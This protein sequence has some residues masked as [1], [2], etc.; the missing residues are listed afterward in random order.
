MR[1][2]VILSSLLHFALFIL[3]FFGLPNFMSR[4][5]DENQV[6]TVEILPVSE[7]TNVKPKSVK[8]QLKPMV[9]KEVTSATPQKQSLPDPVQKPEIAKIAEPTPKLKE[10][11]KEVKKAEVAP[12]VKP[13]EEKKPEPDKTV[14]VKKEVEPELDFASVLKSVEQFKEVKSDEKAKEED[15]FDDVEDFLSNV[16]EQQ[17]KPGIPLSLSEKDAIRQQ[18]SRNWTG[19][20]GGKSAGEIVVTLVI[21]LA[22][23]GEVTKV[24]NVDSNRYKN[25][26]Y[27]KAMADSAIRAVYKSSPLK[28]LPPEK[29]AVKDGW[30]E[31]KLNFDPKEMFY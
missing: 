21:H 12:L 30:R 25:D 29:Y 11:P 22:E 10:Q 19:A 17:Y 16:K 13:K 15:N 1:Q 20:W 26:Q 2:G 8:P 28:N 14:A 31:I 9:D 18:I 4:G 27:F 24:E 23:D 7:M 6:I 5:L 3:L